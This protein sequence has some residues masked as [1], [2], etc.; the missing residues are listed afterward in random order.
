MRLLFFLLLTTTA[1]A[2][3]PFVDAAG[4]P[5]TTP[6]EAR[7]PTPAGA[8]RVPVTEGSFAAWL[9]V[10]PLRA[11]RDDVRSYQGDPLRRPAA[12][13]AALD[14]GRGDLQQCA[15][16]AIRLHAEW[17][18]ASGRSRDAAYHFTSG[19]RSAW[20]DWQGGE[21]FAIKG[22]R[23]DRLQGDPR[24]SDWGAYRGWLQYVFRFAGTRSLRF[25]TDAV[26]SDAAIEAGDVFV[27]PGSPGHAVVVLDVATD[28]ERRLALLGQGFMPAE[29]FHVLRDRAAVDGLWFVLP[30][31]AEDRLDTPSWSPFARDTARRFR[32]QVPALGSGT[33]PSLDEQ[34][35]G[36]GEGAEAR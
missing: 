4:A 30:E 22:S 36:R 12:A 14:V 32:R 35:R 16:S 10:L 1:S 17:L 31:G 23:V 11:D 9:R 25:D 27:D 6:L 29:D 33:R 19:D 24:P 8:V 3:S 15:D 26:P 5:P 2:G 28:G 34:G 20:I 13:V 7:F 18:W 21:R